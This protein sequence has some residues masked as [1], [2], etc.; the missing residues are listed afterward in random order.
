MV[1]CCV[2]G[3]LTPE[4]RVGYRLRVDELEHTLPNGC[5]VTPGIRG[6][7]GKLKA[8]LHPIV[9]SMRFT[10]MEIRTLQ[11]LADRH[12]CSKAQVIRLLI[13]AC[14]NTASST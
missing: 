2:V 5:T 6:M 10:Q 11:L 8:N 13:A 14:T 12:N 1:G 7:K 9:F 4:L 3:S